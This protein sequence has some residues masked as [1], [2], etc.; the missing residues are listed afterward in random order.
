MKIF[1]EFINDLSDINHDISEAEYKLNYSEKKRIELIDSMKKLDFTPE[2]K[3][4]CYIDENP[5]FVRNKIIIDGIKMSEIN[6]DN[7]TIETKNNKQYTLYIL[8]NKLNKKRFCFE[9][10]EEYN[11]VTT[12]HYEHIQYNDF[13]I[14]FPEY[15]F[16]DLVFN[17]ELTKL[18]QKANTNTDDINTS[19]KNNKRKQFEERYFVYSIKDV[20]FC[21][22]YWKYFND[23]FDNN[24]EALWIEPKKRPLGIKFCVPPN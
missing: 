21:C 6:F 17:P 16:D 18:V 12:T 8:I 10:D 9:V 4:K 19:E 7:Y 5:S 13:I 15:N 2:E 22:M 14:K 24:Y 20:N 23:Y 11:F 3:L 1:K